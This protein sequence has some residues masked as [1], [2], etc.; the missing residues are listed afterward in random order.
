M[1]SDDESSARIG[2]VDRMHDAR[3][4]A[5]VVGSLFV[6]ISMFSAIVLLEPIVEM[7]F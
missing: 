1:I 3:T 6:S 5:S 2:N 7:L 4:A